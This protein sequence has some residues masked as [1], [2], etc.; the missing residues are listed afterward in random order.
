MFSLPVGIRWLDLLDVLIVAVFLYQ[1]LLWLK[2]TAGMQLLRGLIIIFIVYMLGKQLELRTVEWLLEKFITVLLILIIIVFQ[3]E[4][5]RG[6]EKLG[7][8]RFWLRLNGWRSGEGSKFVK[9]LIDTIMYCSE[10]TTGALIVLERNTGLNDYLES[11]IMIDA[12]LSTELLLSIFNKNSPLHDGAVIIQHDRIAAAGCLLPLSE[13]RLL[14][15]N[16]GTRHRAAVGTSEQTDAFVI[17]VSEKDGAVSIAENGYLTRY[18][19]RELLEEKLFNAYTLK[20]KKI[21]LF[22]WKKQKSP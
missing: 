22:P 12:P 17:V 4:L 13:S 6:L 8:G 11:G 21:E 2:G 5:R 19:T 15:K 18:L 3:P 14:D 1:I 7:R 20:T 10:N 16:L 9:E